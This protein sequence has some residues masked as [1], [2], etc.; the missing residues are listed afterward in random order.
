CAWLAIQG[1]RRRSARLGIISATLLLL[2]CLQAHVRRAPCPYILSSSAECPPSLQNRSVSGRVE[3]F[4][5]DEGAG[6]PRSCLEQ[7]EREARHA[8]FRDRARCKPIPA[9]PNG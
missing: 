4:P 6:R 7:Q 1:G 5:F 2:A 9:V 8:R 3:L